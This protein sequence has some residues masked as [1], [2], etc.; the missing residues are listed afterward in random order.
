MEGRAL[1]PPNK[2]M[3]TKYVAL[4]QFVSPVLGHINKGQEITIDVPSADAG[5]LTTIDQ[6][7]GLGDLAKVE[8]SV[9]EPVADES[10]AGDG[11][12]KSDPGPSETP[13]LAGPSED[14]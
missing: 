4:R 6:L 12:P 7:V 3:T 14:K 10:A 2:T 5:L 11:E 1:H 9:E 8:E 13:T